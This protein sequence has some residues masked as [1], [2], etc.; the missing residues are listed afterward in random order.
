MI[1]GWMPFSKAC[2]FITY[3]RSARNVYFNTIIWRMKV[4]WISYLVFRCSVLSKKNF[5]DFGGD[6]THICP[7][8]A[9]YRVSDL[10]EFCW[11]SKVL[12]LYRRSNYENLTNMVSHEENYQSC[13]WYVGIH[14]KFMMSVLLRIKLKI[15]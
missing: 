2:L 10:N 6:E 5:I 12:C 7:V 8:N 1:L 4:G 13:T 14:I 15:L 3:K 11:R 9:T